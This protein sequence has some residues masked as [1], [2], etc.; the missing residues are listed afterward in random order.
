MQFISAEIIREQLDWKGMV[1]ALRTMFAQGCEAPVRHHHQMSLPDQ[2]D[3]TML[4]MPAW[5]PGKYSGV[6]L[7]NVYPDNYRKGLPSIMGSY[8]LMDGTSGAPIALLEAAEL[9]ARRTA[10]ASAL[11]SEYLSRANAEKLLIVGSGRMA[12]SLGFAHAVVRPISEIQVW[13][14]NQDKAE[15]VADHYRQAGFNARV[16]LSLKKA[17]DWADIVSCSTMSEE[18]LVLG[19]W[20]RPGTH[21]DLVGAFKPSMR[22]TDD[23]LVSMASVYADT[24]AGV[25]AEGGDLLI[26]MANGS[27]AAEDIC[28]EL[29]ELVREQQP[30]RITE[31]QITL[32]KSVGASLEDLAA[33][34]YCYEKVFPEKE[35]HSVT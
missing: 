13:A 25:L 21:I 35:Q 6:K 15:Q 9:T 28:G 14:R 7:V 16:E 19:E 30:G 33:A 27:F 34:I 3:A 26:P 12:M 22:E 23:N 18:P 2:A 11:A 17:V 31:D 32:F 20:V 10:G 5:T 29:S 1:E 24:R 4:I 8:L